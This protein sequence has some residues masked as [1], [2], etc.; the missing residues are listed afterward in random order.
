MRLVESTV[1]QLGVL[2]LAICGL[3]IYNGAEGLTMKDWMDYAQTFLYT[4]AGKESMKYG[5]TAYKD[6]VNAAQ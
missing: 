1:F 4:Y 2:M 6:K 5:A 3:A